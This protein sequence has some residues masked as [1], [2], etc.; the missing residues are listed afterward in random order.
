MIINYRLVMQRI[1]HEI[2]ALKC[3][4]AKRDYSLT[5]PIIAQIHGITFCSVKVGDGGQQ[6]DENAQKFSS[7][8]VSPQLLYQVRSE[9]L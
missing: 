9:S 8:L 6:G 5:N 4:W 2:V 1:S 3:I 7:K